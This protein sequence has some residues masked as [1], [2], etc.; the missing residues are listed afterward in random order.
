VNCP[1]ILAKHSEEG[2]D[3]TTMLRQQDAKLVQPFWCAI[4]GNTKKA[5]K[6]R[7][8]ES[9]KWLFLVSHF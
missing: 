9:Q 2:R 5:A 7:L 4:F 8:L 1:A 3:S 6:K